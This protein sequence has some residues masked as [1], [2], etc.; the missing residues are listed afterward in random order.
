MR[1]WVY[2]GIVLA[3]A[4]ALV[5]GNEEPG[6]ELHHSDWSL[7]LEGDTGRSF[8]NLD[9]FLFHLGELMSIQLYVIRLYL[10]RPL[11]SSFRERIMIVTDLA[12]QCAW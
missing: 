4:C 3:G 2:A 8:K 1:K 12:N 6:T 9:H 5:V 11:D 7:Y 10:M